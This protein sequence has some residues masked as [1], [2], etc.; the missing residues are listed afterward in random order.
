[1]CK[2]MIMYSLLRSAKLRSAKLPVSGVDMAVAITDMNPLTLGG[3][4]RDGQ[5]SSSRPV[6]NVRIGTDPTSSVGMPIYVG[7]SLLYDGNLANL[8]LINMVAGGKVNVSYYA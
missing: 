7:T 4:G 8:R 5:P 6:Q 2:L 3:G 1:M